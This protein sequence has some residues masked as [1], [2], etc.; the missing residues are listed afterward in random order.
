LAGELVAARKLD[1]AEFVG[2]MA[3]RGIVCVARSDPAYPAPLRELADPPLAIYAAGAGAGPP[4][5]VPGRALAIVGARRAG[6]PALALARRL[7]AFAAGSGVCVVSGLALGVDAAGHQ[8]ALDVEG[9]T[10]AI[11]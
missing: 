1:L 9:P 2:D 7:G 5:V 8:G 4:P 6:A 3:A 11:L 10:I